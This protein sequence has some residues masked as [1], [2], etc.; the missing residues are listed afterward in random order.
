MQ[1][2]GVFRCPSG[3]SCWNFGRCADWYVIISYIVELSEICVIINTAS[4]DISVCDKHTFM[5]ITTSNLALLVFCLLQNHCESLQNLSEISSQA[6]EM[7]DLFWDNNF[8]HLSS[9]A[10]NQ[11]CQLLMYFLHSAI[12]ISRSACHIYTLFTSPL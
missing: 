2:G 6:R 11:Q 8:Q 7:I 10:P 1:A 9:S 3:L 5:C 4:C 12:I